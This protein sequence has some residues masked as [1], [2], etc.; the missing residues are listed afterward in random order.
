VTK[1]VAQ[2]RTSGTLYFF[3]GRAGAGKS[4]LARQLSVDRHAILIC[5]DQ[6]LARL[7]GGVT[8]LQEY[9]E[10]RGQIRRLLADWV[11]Q[12]LQAGHS[13]VFDFGG[14]TIRDRQWVRS[15]FAKVGAEH[16]L[17]YIVASESLCRRRLHDRNRAKPEGV[18]WGDVSDELFD[19]VNKYFQPPTS[20]EGFTIVEH[21]D[22]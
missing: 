7:F 4:T 6:W 16:E 18:Y 11:P 3:T 20:D 14:N 2:Q 10:R 19:E 22:G 21:L 17:H 8:G 1:K 13:V 15:V 12:M 9:L 5:E